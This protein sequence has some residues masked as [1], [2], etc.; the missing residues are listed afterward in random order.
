MSGISIGNIMSNEKVWVDCGDFYEHK[1]PQGSDEWKEARCGR[2]NS[3]NSGALA[4]KSKFK[5][6]E[7]TGKIIAG[8]EFD[9]FTEL[10]LENMNYGTVHESSG[11]IWYENNYKRKVIFYSGQQSGAFVCLCFF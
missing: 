2:I 5:N 1:A 7:D 6:A 11:R 10:Q 3:S 8:V 4:N 9:N